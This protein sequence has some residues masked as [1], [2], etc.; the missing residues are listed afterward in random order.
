MEKAHPEK[1]APAPASIGM[2]G[3]FLQGAKSGAFNSSIMMGIYYAITS[4]S[5][6]GFTPMGMS[7]IALGIVGSTL[8]TGILGAK[9]VYDTQHPSAPAH[10]APVRAPSKARSHA[11]EPEMGMDSPSHTRSDWADRMGRSP[12]SQSRVRE[13]LD[14][15][16]GSNDR[17]SAILEQREH[18]MASGNSRF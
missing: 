11:Q 2:L 16:P 6:L 7:A 18:E 3:G 10:V 1:P 12:G 5:F 4:I 9:K 13:I 17:A 8:F 15:G 14:N